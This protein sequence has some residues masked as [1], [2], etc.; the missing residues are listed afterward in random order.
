LPFGDEEAVACDAQG[1]GVMEPAP[2]ASFVMPEPDF[3]LELLIVALD[4][5]AQFGDVDQ[6]AEGDAVRQGRE[7][8]LGRR[9]FAFRPLDQQPLFG[10][11]RVVSVR[12]SGAHPQAGKAR[13]QPV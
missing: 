1:G 11:R 9:L 13:G 5:P 2:A 4:W 7:P 6:L 12:I 3:L 8:V 10:W